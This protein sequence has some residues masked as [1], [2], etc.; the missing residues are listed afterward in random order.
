MEAV[1]QCQRMLEEFSLEILAFSEL[2]D[3]LTSALLMEYPD[4]TKPFI[5]CTDPCS[6]SVGAILCERLVGN[7]KKTVAYA[8]KAFTKPGLSYCILD[9]NVKL[10]HGH[11][12]IL[13][14]IYMEENFSL[15]VMINHHQGFKH[16]KSKIYTTE[17]EPEIRSI[18]SDNIQKREPKWMPICIKQ[19]SNSSQGKGR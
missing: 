7:K 5:L 18:L 6:F 4:F 12:H 13:G 17:I 19:N 10:Q 11:P 1:M 14:H 3:I 8:N 16:E 9:K 2:K 15:S